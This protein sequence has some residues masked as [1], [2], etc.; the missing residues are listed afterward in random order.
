MITIPKR[1]FRCNKRPTVAVMPGHFS[2]IW[3]I[4]CPKCG[5]KVKTNST[6]LRTIDLWNKNMANIG[7]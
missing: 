1:C 4:T 5:A 3:F 2:Q 7:N 6:R